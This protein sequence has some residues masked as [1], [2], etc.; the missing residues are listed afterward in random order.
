MLVVGILVG[1]LATYM[2][3]RNRDLGPVVVRDVPGLSQ[4]PT[5]AEAQ[6]DPRINAMIQQLEARLA[7]NPGDFQ[8]LL[9]LANLNFDRT[10]YPSAID[11]YSR[12]LDIDPNDVTVRTDMGTA[13]YYLGRADEATAQFEG[14]LAI[15]PTYPQ[16]LFNLGVVL[17]EERNDRAGTIELWERLV[18]TSP[19]WPQI[20]TVREELARLK[21][22]P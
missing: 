6:V 7:Q 4:G 8:T 5:E 19:A 14:A 11:Y 13:L 17:L 9:E 10:D 16:A 15:N 12:A 1:F 21:S 2:A 18:A 20:A 22:E 3:V